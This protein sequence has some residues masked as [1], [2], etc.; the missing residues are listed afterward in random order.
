[1]LEDVDVDAV[2][3]VGGG[4][5]ATDPTAEAHEVQPHLGESIIAVRT[6]LRVA[7]RGVQPP[8]PP[9]VALDVPAEEAHERAP[10]PGRVRVE[11][12]A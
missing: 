4:H 5:R 7:E 12:S 11:S 9:R 3:R 1:V 10:I 2:A 8:D 6:C